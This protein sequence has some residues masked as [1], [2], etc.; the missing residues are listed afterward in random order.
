MSVH[1]FTMIDMIERNALIHPRR[2]ALVHGSKRLTYSEFLEESLRVCGGLQAAGARPGERIAMMAQNCMEYM[3]LFGAAAL[4]GYVLVPVNWRL[5]REEVHSILQDAAPS[6]LVVSPDFVEMTT[7]AER[8]LESVKYRY[9]LGRDKQGDYLPFRDLFERGKG[10][11]P[12]GIG[13]DAPYLILYTAAVAGRAKGAVLSQNNVVALNTML[14]QFFTLGPED[15]QACFLPLFHMAGISLSMAV[16][17]VGGMSV[18]QEKFEADRTLDII[19]AEGVSIL[20]SF[21]PMLD[22]LMEKQGE[23]QRDIT[24]LRT[25][26]GLNPADTI[27]RFL[28]IAPQVRFAVMFGQTEALAVTCGWFDEAPGSAG[29]PAPLARVRIVDDADDEA[30]AGTAGE[31]CV[32]SP[33]VFQGYWGLEEE[34]SWTLRNGWHHTGDMGRLDD[35]GILWYAGRMPAKELIKPGGENVYPA[36]VEKALLAHPSVAEACVIGVP[37]ERWGEAV[38]AVCVL[39]PG[40]SLTEVDLI[41]FVG[42]RLAGYK[43]PR[44]VVF[45]G[46]LPRTVEGVLDRAAVK[47]ENS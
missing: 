4:G 23:R 31:I 15:V 34:T 22:H 26:G 47:K 38:K 8:G 20:Y 27:D 46:A 14:S 43:K 40:H 10:Q 39:E 32:K 1:E 13:G 19:E 18:I 25:I 24:S 35:R 37:D 30:P 33:C 29:R 21:P 28:G 9:T 5:A 11:V 44:H 7:Q 3:T 36:E 2:E 12:A 16:M 42:A 41:S 17:H 45:A 6:F